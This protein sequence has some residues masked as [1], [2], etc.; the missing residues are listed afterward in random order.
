MKRNNF[1]L[2]IILIAALFLPSL[3]DSCKNT[4]DNHYMQEDATIEEN[5]FDD[6]NAASDL[7]TFVGLLKKTDY[8]SILLYPQAYTVFAPV[9]NA[10]S[11][12]SQDTLNNPVLLKALIGNH[13]CRFSYST[14]DVKSNLRL[15]MLNGKYVEFSESGSNFKFGDATLISGD[16]LS[17][18]G[19]L[20]KIGSVVRVKQ[21]IWD[22]MQKSGRFPIVMDYLRPFDTMVFD[23]F[24]SVL[25]G[26]NTLGQAVYD[27]VFIPTSNYFKIVGDLISEEKQYTYLGLPDQ[28]YNKVFDVFKTYYAYPVADTVKNNVNKV[29]INNLVF[30]AFSKSSLTNSYLTNTTGKQVL[31]DKSTVA[32]EIKLS[33]GYMFIMNDL[34]FLPTDIMYKPLRYEVENSD[35][36][37]IGK[38]ADFSIQKIY[39]ISASENFNNEVLLNNNPDATNSNSFF[40][41]AFSNVFSARYDIFIKFAP[42]GA[43]KSSKLKYILTYKNL[44]G[45]TATVNIPGGVVSNTE[46]GRVKIGDT[47]NFPVYVNSLKTN[48]YFVKLKVIIDVSQAELVLYDRRVG[49]DYI[50]LVPVP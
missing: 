22:Y 7:S 39:D 36:R 16:F 20:H 37:T 13:I 43:M 11:G 14:D 50:E 48:T 4:W 3:L 40:E 28:A 26:K 1:N 34:T 32:E 15:K 38:A 18:N 49:I 23:E 44:D 24:N 10:F 29:I 9:N 27:S 30:P 42:I 31:I 8:D 25:T 33:N 45:T 46:Y 35:R 17:K 41:V 6:L 5:L 19:I 47:Y 2:Y 21:N 12:F